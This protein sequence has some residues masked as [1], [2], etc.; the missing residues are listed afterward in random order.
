MSK[1][2]PREGAG[3]RAFCVRAT[4]K[5][6]GSL[7]SVYKQREGRFLKFFLVCKIEDW[8]ELL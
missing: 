8:A 7:G 6:G 2:T 5:F 3:D 4:T 1:R